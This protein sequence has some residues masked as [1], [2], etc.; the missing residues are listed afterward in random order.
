MAL[1]LERLDARYFF[2]SS[3]LVEL[4]LARAVVTDIAMPATYGEETSHLSISSSLLTF[5]VK[6]ARCFARR[7]L[8][9]HLLTDFSPVSL[10]L[11]FSLPLA[12]F[13]VAFGVRS[14]IDSTVYGTAATAGTVMLAAFTTAAGLYGLVQAMIYDIMS[15]PQR[16]LT[17]PRLGLVPLTDL[18][19]RRR[20][21]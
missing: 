14:W 13:G 6:H 20:R 3:M 15:V 9:R 21:R 7:M 19:Q 2:E 11:V 12:A 17:L 4:G 18:A 10:L 1:D 5:G 8:H 16:P